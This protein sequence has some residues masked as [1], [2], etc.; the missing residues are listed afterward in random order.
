MLTASCTAYPVGPWLEA[1]KDAEVEQ[2]HEKG[3]KTEEANRLYGDCARATVG[4]ARCCPCPLR[5][6]PRFKPSFLKLPP[7]GKQ[8]LPS[9]FEFNGILTWRAV[10]GR[11]YGTAERDGAQEQLAAAREEAAAARTAAAADS[12]AAAEAKAR[13]ARLEDHAEHAAV[14]PCR[15]WESLSDCHSMLTRRQNAFR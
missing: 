2:E 9:F 4:P 15:H 13:A 14:R 7:C 11:P 5:H 8:Y 6:P 10:S 12:V 1:A 3:L